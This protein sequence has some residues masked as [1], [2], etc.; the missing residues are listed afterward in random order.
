MWCVI[1]VAGRATRL[2]KIAAGRP[3]ALI[4]AGGRSIIEHL[5]DRLGSPFTDVCLVADPD[6]VAAFVEL[7]SRH[8]DL[9]L[10]YAVQPQPIGVAD[11]VGRAADLV[12]G[13]FVAL[14]GDSFY[15]RPLSSFPQRWAASDSD[16]AV[17]VE[18]AEEADGQPMGLVRVDDRWV[19]EIFK[20]PWAGETDW[21]VCGAYLFPLA[22]FEALGATAP[23]ESGELELEDVVTQL[24]RDGAVFRAIPYAGWRRNINTPR[25]LEVV[26]S[27]LTGG[28]AAAHGIL[29]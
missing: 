18:P 15:E 14:M 8:G 1:P 12:D 21:R 6:G 23:A 7:G 20:G 2:Q 16:G 22:F 4:R 9:S 11:A 25:D 26:E 10:H 19:A 17:L 3:K 24:M 27:R 29:D 13:P 28:S 5:L